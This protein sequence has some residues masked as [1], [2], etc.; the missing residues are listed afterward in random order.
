MPIPL[1]ERPESFVAR[2]IRRKVRSLDGVADCA[3][4]IMGFTRK[5]P[6]IHLRVSLRGSPGFEETHSI[7]STIEGAVRHIVPNSHVDIYS[8]SGGVE[9]AEAVWKAVKAIADGEPGSRGAQSIHL[10]RTDGRMGVDF[11]IIESARATDALAGHIE[12]LVEKRFKTADPNV[13]EVVVHSETVS[14]LVSS[15]LSRCGTETRWLIEHVAG[16]FPELKLSGPPALQM[17]GDLMRVGIQVEFRGSGGTERA[18]KSVSDLEN[19]IRSACP[20]I[21]KVD[22]ITGPEGRLD[23]NPDASPPWSG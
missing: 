10:N 2:R 1:I 16:R 3:G 21:T 7:C 12:T 11:L 17:F 13:S 9:D 15:E 19:A 5:K 14:E 6:S 22:I 20:M 23:Q 18:M 4:V 8:Q